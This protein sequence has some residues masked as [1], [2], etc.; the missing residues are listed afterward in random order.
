MSASDVMKAAEGVSVI[1]H[2]VN[3]PGYRDWEKLVLPMIDNTIAAAGAVGA[4]IVLPGTLYNFGPDSFPTLREDSP[5]N[6]VTKKGAIRV[7]MEKRGQAYRSSSSAPGIFSV[8][9]LPTAGF[10]RA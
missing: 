3:P 4:R 10:P 6:P 2:A 8:R 7:E 5:Q 1:V 9:L